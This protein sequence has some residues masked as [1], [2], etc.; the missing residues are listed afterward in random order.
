MSISGYQYYWLI[1][2]GLVGGIVESIYSDIS[3]AGSYYIST[4]FLIF[5]GVCCCV[6]IFELWDRRKWMILLLLSVSIL[7][8]S[9]VHDS[10]NYL[11]QFFLL[12]YWVYTIKGKK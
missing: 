2:I 6:V 11:A 10:F 9:F 3:P 5:S 8:M 7:L 1:L 12:G 4:I